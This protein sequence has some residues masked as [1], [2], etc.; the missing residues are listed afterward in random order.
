M[1]L[2]FNGVSPIIDE[3]TYISENASIIGSVTLKKGANIWFSAVLRGDEAE[4]VIGEDSNVQDNATVHGKV[5]VG[6]GVTVGHNAILHGCTVGDNSLIGMGATVLDG[7][8]IGKNCIIGAGA[9]VTGGTVIP[10]GSL[11]LGAPAKVKRE[12]SDTEVEANS[13]NA[14]EYLH[15]SALYKK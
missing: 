3:D 13:K 9:L 5:T 7:A 10:D 15:L 14:R 11:A 4:I 8:V 6:K 12:L 2:D 1:I